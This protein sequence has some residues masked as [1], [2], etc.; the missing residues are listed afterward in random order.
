[1]QTGTNE[2]YDETTSSFTKY[3]GVDFEKCSIKTTLQTNTQ[4]VSV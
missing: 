2:R 4:L 3:E 1:M